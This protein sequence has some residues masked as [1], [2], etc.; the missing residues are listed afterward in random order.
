MVDQRRDHALG[1][2]IETELMVTRDVEKMRP[3][4]VAASRMRSWNRLQSKRDD[5]A[6]HGWL[7]RRVLLA[8]PPRKCA[9]TLAGG[10][11]RRTLQRDGFAMVSRGLASQPAGRGKAYLPPI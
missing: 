7:A 2:G 6:A 4:S 3:T 10:G 8:A 9:L 5:H 1:A 11:R